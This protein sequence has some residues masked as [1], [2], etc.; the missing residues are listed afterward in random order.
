MK[1]RRG[2]EWL[3]ILVGT[4]L[5]VGLIAYA[6]GPKHHRGDEIGSHGTKVVVVHTVP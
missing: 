5:V 4:L 1:M 6:R 2:I 3:L